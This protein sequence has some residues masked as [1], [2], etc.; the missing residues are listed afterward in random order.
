MARL[1]AATCPKCGAGV[2]LD[3]KNQF[4]TCSYCGVSSFVETPKRPATAEIRQAARP[5]IH[6]ERV[7]RSPFGCLSLLISLV[8]LIG[9]GGAFSGQLLGNLSLLGGRVL[10]VSSGKP[11]VLPISLPS[12]VS[13]LASPRVEEDLFKDPELVKRRFEERLGKPLLAKEVVLYPTY[14]LVEAQDPKN[15]Q[16]LDRYWYRNGVVDEPEPLQVSSSDRDKLDKLV[17]PLDLISF[18]K[19][20]SVIEGALKEIPIEQGKVSHVILTRDMFSKQQPVVRVYVSGPRDGGGYIEYDGS[21]KRRRV[22]H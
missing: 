19:L 2:R 16:H 15:K 4:V 6:V 18:D 9:L 20:A 12:A 7:P 1:I 22:V 17:F 8:V 11:F 21:G 13:G 5:I 10:G 3:P 14:A